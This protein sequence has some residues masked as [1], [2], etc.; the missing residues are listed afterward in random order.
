LEIQITQDLVRKESITPNDAG[1][2]KYIEEFLA[3][4]GFIN[5]TLTYG[6]VKN[7]WSINR[8]P[9]PLLIF[10]GH[11]DVVPT[12]PIE[13]WDHAPFSGHDDGTYIYGRGTGDMKGGIA[14]FMSALSRIDPDDLNFS[15]GFI[16]TADEEGPSRDGTVKVVDE[17]LQR[18][19][20]VDYCLIGEPSTIE[21]VG[22]NI[23]IGRRGSINIE[24][25]VLGKQGHAAYPARVDNPIHKVVPFLD[26]LLSEVWDEGNEHFPP[27]S[28]Q[29]TNISAGVGAHNVTPNNLNLKFNLRFSTQITEDEIQ[30]KVTNFLEAEGIKHKIQFDLNAKPFYSE[31]K[32]FTEVVQKSISEVQAFDTALSCSG[33]TSDGRFM[34]KTGCEIVE[35]G[36]KFET[37]HKINEKIEKEELERL[38]DIYYQILLNLNE[39]TNN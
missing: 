3:K 12:G 31:P 34:A 18:G 16:I 11:V 23:R 15:L 1:C 22:D 19:E 26:K 8:K 25:E 13:Q 10:L 32:L 2:L 30:T 36:P 37:I 6:R 14:C 20:V 7:L 39:E 21:T 9:G 28:L 4:R 27:T 24:L 17:L 35:L 38:T 29:L 33:G 5:E